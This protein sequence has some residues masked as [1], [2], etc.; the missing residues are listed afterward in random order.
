MNE[1]YQPR[2]MRLGRL[3]FKYI[4]NCELERRGIS[5]EILAA[6]M[7]KHGLIEIVGDEYRELI[8]QPKRKELIALYNQTKGF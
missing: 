2:L 6:W 3:Y 8:G 7:E 5:T 1:A 4:R